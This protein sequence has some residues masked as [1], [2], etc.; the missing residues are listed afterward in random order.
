MAAMCHTC[1][2]G[3][4][5]NLEVRASVMRRIFTEASQTRHSTG[6]MHGKP[7][8]HL[9]RGARKVQ[10]DY[11]YKTGFIDAPTDEAWYRKLREI[12]AGQDQRPRLS[13]KMAIRLAL[14]GFMRAALEGQLNVGCAEQLI[15]KVL[16]GTVT[17]AE[18]LFILDREARL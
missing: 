8:T 13:R 11:F 5:G 15:S 4:N 18:Q 7:D 9:C 17:N 16:R 10:I 3:P 14:V 1:P 6:V 2:F 12:E